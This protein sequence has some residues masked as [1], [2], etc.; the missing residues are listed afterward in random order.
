MKPLLLF[1]VFVL[2]FIF[3]HSQEYVNISQGNTCYTNKD[4]PCAAE[5]YKLAI[6]KNNYQQ[7]DYAEILYRI[8][9]SLSYD[10]SKLDEAISYLNDALSK[11][12]DWLDIEYSLGR[13]YE[14]KDDFPNAIIHY[15]KAADFYKSKPKDKWAQESMMGIADCYYSLNRIDDCIKACE[16]LIA[17]DANFFDPYYKLGRIYLDQSKYVEA[18]IQFDRC[19]QIGGN[20]KTTLA[21]AYTYRARAKKKL[22]KFDAAIEDVNKAFEVNPATKFG[23]W[24]K[25]NIYHDNGKYYDA[26][27]YY[28]KA[29]D[30][31]TAD[32][33]TLKTLYYWTAESYLNNKY[34]DSAARYVEKAIQI[35]NNISIYHA[36]LGDCHFLRYAYKNAIKSYNQSIIKAEKTTTPNQLAE[37]YRFIG[38][39]YAKQGYH[40]TARIYYKKALQL[41]PDNK[42]TI[43]DV[44]AAYYNEKKYND[45]IT[46]YNKCITLY[47]EDKKSLGELYYWKS[48]SNLYLKKY[49]LA[50]TDINEALKLYPDSLSGN[51]LKADVFKAAKKY[52]EAIATYGKTIT[53]S[54]YKTYNHGSLYNSRGLCYLS[55]KDTAL[56]IEDFKKSVSADYYFKD[57]RIELAKIYFNRNDYYAAYDQSS[58]VI[59]GSSYLDT[60]LKAELYAIRGISNMK[61]AYYYSAEADLE[62]S[63]KYDSTNKKALRYLA[64]CYYINSK[65]EKAVKAMTKCISLYK[66]VKDSLP[67]MYS[68]RGQMYNALKKYK[69]AGEDFDMAAKLDPKEID[70]PYRSGQAWFEQK[71]YPKAIAAFKKMLALCKPTEKD[72]ISFAY[73]AIGRCEYELKNKAL[74]ITNLN[75]AIEVKADYKDAKDWLDKIKKDGN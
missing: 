23:M 67:I 39:S 26:I 6:S 21:N 49:D 40:D 17:Y 72:Y 66:N 62:I 74:A 11:K 42:G 10:H 37:R 8:G 55:S 1:S 2:S 28:K 5:N 29:I 69:E 38:K 58:N 64:E 45:A 15:R 32:T 51:W 52:P 54:K 16:Q 25:A 27:T 24:E 71:D 63:Q 68:Y 41:A 12:P 13:C 75:K 9:I 20:D 33:A 36:L 43:W 30:L 56:A 46:E 47:K 18:V 34:Y 22:D 73:F 19:I 53:L 48:Y 60:A 57:P 61:K 3:S 14:E 31:Y 7:K 35:N 50:L 70:H 44:A 65:F 59:S 4:Y